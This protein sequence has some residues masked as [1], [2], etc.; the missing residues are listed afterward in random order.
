MD[1]DASSTVDATTATSIAADTSGTSASAGAG[2]GTSSVDNVANCWRY[3]ADAAVAASSVAA[4]AGI[5]HSHSVIGHLDA[6][7][8]G[9]TSERLLEHND[10]VNSPVSA[11]AFSSLSLNAEDLDAARMRRAKYW[12]EKP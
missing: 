12:L 9:I 4:T 8:D 3:S 10:D 6:L 11:P 1:D 7:A 2:T 5:N